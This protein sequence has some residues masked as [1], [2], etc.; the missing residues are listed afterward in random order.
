MMA[1]FVMAV[2]T[3]LFIIAL[4]QFTVVPLEPCVSFSLSTTSKTKI[5]PATIEEVVDKFEAWNCHHKQ[6]N[7]HKKEESFLVQHHLPPRARSSRL[8][9]F[10]TTV[11]SSSLP[12]TNAAN[13]ACRSG[14][15]QINHTKVSGGIFVQKGDFL[16][17]CN[18][19]DGDRRTTLPDDPERSQRFC[20]SRLRLLQSL[21][22][23]SLTH[24]PLRV[25]YEDDTMAIVC[26]PAGIHTMSWSGSFGNFLCLDEILPLL[27]KPPSASEADA[28][29]SPLPRHRLDQR[30]AGPVVV[31][32]T[33]QAVIT[34]GHMFEYKTVR[35]EYRAIVA[36]TI[37]K[38]I[39]SNPCVV[40]SSSNDNN[41]HSSFTV[42]S[43]VD[44]K[45]SETEVVVLGTVPC[46]IY[47]NLTDLQLFPKTGRKH[48]LRIHCAQL[49]QTPILGDDL[50]WNTTS[51]RELPPVGK[52][53][54]LY[55]Y[56]KKVTLNHP[57]KTEKLVSGEI[58]EPLRFRRTREKALKGYMY[59]QVQESS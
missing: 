30:V 21:A 36:G 25:L 9:H 40:S 49:L 13:L 24:A 50:Y 19:Q 41:K 8:S 5:I 7:N 18:P 3:R 38:N 29:S 37:D 27:L 16:T 43:N 1:S 56:C 15:L 52:R 57:I 4:M 10:A 32:K 33:R 35:K 26:K 23:R 31:A 2:T 44:G 12:S 45:L 42:Q 54:G 58:R 53:Q 6:N 28:L 34:I 51:S 59:T 47:G 17:Y 48:Q 46:H 11:F 55:L 22:N 39:M 20:Q 14:A